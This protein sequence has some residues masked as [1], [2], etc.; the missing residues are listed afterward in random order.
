ML[1]GVVERI[2]TRNADPSGRALA[3]NR[4]GRRDKEMERRNGERSQTSKSL[5]ASFLRGGVE[6][7]QRFQRAQKHETRGD[8]HLALR[9]YEGAGALKSAARMRARITATPS[10]EL[11]AIGSVTSFEVF[12]ARRR[13]ARKA[14]TNDPKA[15]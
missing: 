3:G 11:Q 9:A 7:Y 6:R 8:F 10:P 14:I 5:S 2:E 1:H 12:W 4:P 13:E 15:A